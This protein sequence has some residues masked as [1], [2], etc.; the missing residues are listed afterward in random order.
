MGTHNWKLVSWKMCGLNTNLHDLLNGYRSNT[1]EERY[2]ES[3]T[4]L[5]R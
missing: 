4:M 3:K 1:Q 2:Q 5:D